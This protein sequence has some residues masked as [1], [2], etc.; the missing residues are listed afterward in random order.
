MTEPARPRVIP[1]RREDARPGPADESDLVRR[2]SEGQS[3]AQGELFRRHAPALTA[4]LTR[5]LSSRVD[6]EDAV[7]DAFIVAFRDLR[8]LRETAAFGGWLRQIG[9]HQAQRRFRRRRLLAVL[10][11]DASVQDAT[12]EALIDPALLPDRRTEVALLDRLLAKLP[13]AER[14]AWMLRYVE[15]YELTEVARTC[16]CS[17]ATAKRRISAAAAKISAHVEI[18]EATDVEAS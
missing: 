15:G 3:W 4:L 11:F 17:L 2:A 13:A 8:Q 1:L 6:A 7:Q 5:L 14:M 16:E 9:V 18:E 12:L 10:G